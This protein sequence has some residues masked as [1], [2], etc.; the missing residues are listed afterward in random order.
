[1]IKTL[2]RMHFNMD[3]AISYLTVLPLTGA[4][5][6]LFARQ[7]IESVNAGT[8]DPL[9]L[10]IQLK[11]IENTIDFIRKAPSVKEAVIKEYSKYIGEGNTVEL[12][13][14]RVNVSERK[15]YEYRDD[16]LNALK[17]EL[18]Q[19]KGRIKS[20]EILL[21]TNDAD[22]TTGEIFKKSCK[23]TQVVKILF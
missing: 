4:E 3:N 1:M 22:P 6:D 10:D 11:A 16:E 12:H 23:K 13:G 19:I 2:R 15:T 8:V 20:R 9:K 17:Q 5:Q 21:Q 14:A 18:E 7:V